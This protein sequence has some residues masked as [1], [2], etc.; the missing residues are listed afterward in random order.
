MGSTITNYTSEQIDFTA[1]IQREGEFH[2]AALKNA[3]DAYWLWDSNLPEAWHASSEFFRL[4]GESISEHSPTLKHWGNLISNSSRFSFSPREIFDHFA[5]STEV[6]E[7]IVPYKH[8]EGH[9]VYMKTTAVAL[10]DEDGRPSR[11]LG[12]C[13]DYSHQLAHLDQ[14]NNQKNRLLHIIDGANLGTFEWNIQSGECIFNERWAE[15]VGYEPDD[16]MPNI[17]SWNNLAHEDDLRESEIRLKEHF[18]GE[19]E[20]YEMETRM[21]H[22]EGRWVWVRDVGKVISWTPDGLPLLMAGSHQDIT[23]KKLLCQQREHQNETL[24][25]FAHIVSHNLRSHC[26]NMSMLLQ[27]MKHEVPEQYH[28]GYMCM[29]EAASS[30]LLLT[31]DHLNEL[32]SSHSE[33]IEEKM[34]PL[35]LRSF[36][37]RILD[38]VKADTLAAKAEI[39]VNVDHKI[40]ICGLPAFVESIILNVVTNA[41]KYRDPLRRLSITI[42]TTV[43]D[44]FCKLQVADNGLGIDMEK[45]GEDLFGMYKTFHNHP[46]AVGVGLCISRSQAQVMGGSLEASSSPGVGS[47]FTATFKLAP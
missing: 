3:A 28:V 15:I 35:Q 41:L 37:D 43:Q 29:L 40:C 8:Q 38:T 31:I 45:H 36:I 2:D 11:I 6:F 20:F 10:F 34:Q 4:I 42:S 1:L 16:V 9:S 44:G 47:T 12:I 25:N 22:R 18:D 46:D 13:N 17:S 39:E 14:T 5:I 26:G 21:R 23:E 32:V 30:S 7:R 24:S 19:T 33:T 27:L